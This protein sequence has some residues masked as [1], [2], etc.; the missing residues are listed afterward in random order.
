[1]QVSLDRASRR[2]G[3]YVPVEAIQEINGSTSLFVVGAESRAAVVPVNV[4]ES[5]GE[6]RRVEAP[7]LAAGA[8]VVIAGAHFLS[9]GDP[10]QVVGQDEEHG[11]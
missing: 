5:A 2:P 1:M 8:A 4:T 9:H 10:V 11:Q 7:E 6:Y 3:F